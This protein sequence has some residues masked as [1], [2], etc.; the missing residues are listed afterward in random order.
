MMW[1]SRLAMMVPSSSTFSRLIF[2][3]AISPGRSGV[4]S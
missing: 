1:M 3:F 2:I 4:P